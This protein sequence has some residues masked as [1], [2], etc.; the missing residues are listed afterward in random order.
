MLYIIL[1]SPFTTTRMVSR[2]QMGTDLYLDRCEKVKMMLMVV[3]V[4]QDI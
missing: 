3:M 4:Y 1:M 2:L